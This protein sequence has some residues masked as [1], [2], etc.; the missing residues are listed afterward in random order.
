[1]PYSKSSIHEIRKAVEQT[2]AS[3]AQSRAGIQDSV[4]LKVTDAPETLKSA[5]GN[6]GNETASTSAEQFVRCVEAL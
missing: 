4:G 6:K 5:P 1:M 3:R 2:P